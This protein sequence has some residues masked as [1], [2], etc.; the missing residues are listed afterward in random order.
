MKL[1]AVVSLS[2]GLSVAIRPAVESDRPYILSSWSRHVIFWLRHHL[3][4]GRPDACIVNRRAERL[5]SRHGAIVAVNP[6][7][8]EQM[9]GWVCRDGNRNVVHYAYVLAPFRRLG[10]ARTL[11]AGLQ[12]PIVATH[13]SLDCETLQASGRLEYKPTLA[14]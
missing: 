2:D 3:G 14:R 8:P 7:L 5:L 1:G 6:E 9:L 12:L 4:I 13:W 10:V 11:C